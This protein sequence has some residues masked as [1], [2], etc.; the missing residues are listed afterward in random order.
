M[1]NKTPSIE[2][3]LSFN[4]KHNLENKNTEIYSW[5]NLIFGNKQKYNS[6]SNQRQL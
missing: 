1:N 4:K 2:Y 3:N 5:L 6:E